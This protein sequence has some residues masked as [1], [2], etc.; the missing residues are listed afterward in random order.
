MKT[1]SETN[2][3]GYDWDDVKSELTS[4]TPEDIDEIDFEV[5]LMGAFIE[6]RREKGLTQAE[7]NLLC[8]IKQTHIARIE[9]GKTDPQLSTVLKLLRPLGK[10]LAVVDIGFDD[11]HAQLRQG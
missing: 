9:T 3:C 4:L 2:E 7:L 1:T 8:G 5:Q 10:K 6:A 11:E